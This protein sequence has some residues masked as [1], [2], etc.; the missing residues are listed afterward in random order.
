MHIHHTSRS[1][2]FD[3]SA[4][5]CRGGC[6]GKHIPVSS[7]VWEFIPNA[8]HLTTCANQKKKR[9]KKQCCKSFITNKISW[10]IGFWR[11]KLKRKSLHWSFG[12]V[13]CL[14]TFWKCASAII[15]FE[16]KMKMATIWENPNKSN[17]FQTFS[18]LWLDRLRPFPLFYF[19]IK[20][21]SKTKSPYLLTTNNCWIVPKHKW[22]SLPI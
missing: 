2:K 8:V 18:L 6:R 10:E 17:R 12:R 20:N 13:L 7:S 5:K 1:R 11:A 22:E 9:E 14:L 15:H 19:T 4:F 16:T 3:R 21:A